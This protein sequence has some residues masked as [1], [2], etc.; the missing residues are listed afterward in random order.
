MKIIIFTDSLGRPRPDIDI[1]ERTNYCDVYGSKLQQHFGVKHIIELIYIE[2][3]DTEDAIFWGERMVAFREPDLVIFQFGVN[4]CAP[5]IFRKGT[6]LQCILNNHLFMMVT[7]NIIPRV[8]SKFRL[9]ITK[10]FKKVYVELESFEYNY[11]KIMENILIYNR[12]CKF[13]CLSILKSDELN[14]KSYGFNRNVEC[15][16]QILRCIFENN[17]ID[18]NS[19]FLSHP[20]LI[21]DGVHMTKKAHEELSL[22]LIGEIEKICVE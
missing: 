5:R 22:L 20:Y 10:Y 15:Y 18:L 13:I 6:L 2:S 21:T 8:A 9:Q 19:S 16:N 12:D 1:S 17:F 11:I 3:L 4:D 7:K 14:K